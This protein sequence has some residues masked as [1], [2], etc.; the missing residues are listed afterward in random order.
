MGVNLSQISNPIGGVTPKP[1]PSKP[2]VGKP[3]VK[4]SPI[5]TLPFPEPPPKVSPPQVGP[6]QVGP[7]QEEVEKRLKAREMIIPRIEP[8]IMTNYELIGEVRFKPN[9]LRYYGQIF[10]LLVKKIEIKNP[11]KPVMISYDY[12]VVVP[13][14]WGSRLLRLTTHEKIKSGQVVGVRS[15]NIIGTVYTGIAWL[16]NS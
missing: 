5:Q 2:I 9:T 13:G 11:D 15:N 16:H 1:S 14:F 8:S 7:S 3:I 4:P 6:P 12:R 10:P